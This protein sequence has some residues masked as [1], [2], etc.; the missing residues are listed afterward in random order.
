MKKLLAFIVLAVVAGVYFKSGTGSMPPLPA[1]LAAIKC[2]QD[3]AYIA[4]QGYDTYKV[5]DITLFSP[6]TKPGSISDYA[7]QQAKLGFNTSVDYG[8]VRFKSAHD[9]VGTFMITDDSS[10][11]LP[12]IDDTNFTV[13]AHWALSEG[14]AWDKRITSWPQVKIATPSAFSA[15]GSATIFYCKNFNGP[16]IEECWARARSGPLFWRI[17][18]TFGQPFSIRMPELDIT[19]ALQ[20]VADHIYQEGGTN[21]G[22]SA[23]ATSPAEF[24]IEIDAKTLA[25]YETEAKAALASAEPGKDSSFGTVRWRSKDIPIA[26]ARNPYEITLS[27]V[28][29]SRGQGAVH[30]RWK[31]L[32]SV[33]D[34]MT[35][36]LPIDDL[37]TGELAMAESFTLTSAAAP[38]SFSEGG[39]AFLQVDLME[40]DNAVIDKVTVHVKM[41]Q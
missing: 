19:R 36:E 38:Y 16:P 3:S 11:P 21:A 28:G 12:N 23:A 35:I 15:Y 9:A 27:V 37:N 5:K 6:C 17:H 41:R 1:A 30:T 2:Q 39:S 31:V 40:L 26:F 8:E 18:I 13:A 24:S 7:R 22:T 33:E 14:D 4:A 32:W 29:H 10:D 34:R 20:L 25:N